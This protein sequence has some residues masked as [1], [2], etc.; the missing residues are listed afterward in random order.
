MSFFT[1]FLN[2]VWL[3]TSVFMIVVVLVQRGKGGGLAGALGGAGGSSAFG[4]KAGDVF[5][6]I[7]VGVFV[8]WLLLAVSLVKVMEGGASA[9]SVGIDEVEKEPAAET[10]TNTNTG[11]PAIP[12]AGTIDLSKSV[13][14]TGAEKSEKDESKS[15]KPD[16]AKKADDDATKTDA[17]KSDKKEDAPKADDA[18]D[19]SKKEEPA[20]KEPADN[21]DSK[22]KP[23]PDT[24]KE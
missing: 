16:S 1:Y 5:T 14:P 12:G 17:A 13:K 9:P 3:L 7:T 23:T 24:T 15:E 6:K 2:F 4:T 10:K 11:T 21:T 20:K 19:E 18:G 8:F 22:D